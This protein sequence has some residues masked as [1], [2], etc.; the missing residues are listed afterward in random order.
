M[1]SM[2]NGMLKEISQNLNRIIFVEKKCPACR[3]ITVSDLM[4]ESRVQG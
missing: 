4:K 3:V 2:E 1:P